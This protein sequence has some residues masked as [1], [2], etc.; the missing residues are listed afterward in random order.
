[1]KSLSKEEFVHVLRRQSTG[2]SRGSSSTEASPC[3][4][5]AGGRLAWGS[6]SAKSK[7]LL[8]NLDYLDTVEML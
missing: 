8:R 1:M 7:I 3:T 6:S 2:F 5:A 4:S